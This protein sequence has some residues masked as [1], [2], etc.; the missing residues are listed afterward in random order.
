[1]IP[2]IRIVRGEVESSDN[3]TVYELNI[4]PFLFIA[5]CAISWFVLGYPNVGMFEFRWEY[6]GIGIASGISL[7]LAVQFL[8]YF[9][10][11]GTARAAEAE[12]AASQPKNQPTKNKMLLDLVAGVTEEAFFRGVVQPVLTLFLGPALAIILSNVAFGLAHSMRNATLLFVTAFSGMILGVLF[13]LT[14]SLIAAMA[15][16][17]TMNAV[18]NVAAQINRTLT[19]PTSPA[20]TTIK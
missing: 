1:M 7:F 6:L 4:S 18:M 15:A 16:H 20:S 11:E 3:S 13:F 10:S 19:A 14:G 5:V 9:I 8:G 12:Q 17:I 2:R